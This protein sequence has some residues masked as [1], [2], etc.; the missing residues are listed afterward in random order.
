MPHKWARVSLTGIK[1][2]RS[3]KQRHPDIIIK[4][5]EPVSL[6][7]ETAFNSESAEVFLDNLQIVIDKHPQFSDETRKFNLTETITTTIHKRL[8]LQEASVWAE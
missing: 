6:A 4:K 2:F 3:S 7:K 1:W 8:Q 5:P